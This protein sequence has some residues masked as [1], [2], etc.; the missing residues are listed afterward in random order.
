MIEVRNTFMPL[1]QHLREMSA[2]G[3]L[4]APPPEDDSDWRDI[5]AMIVN[6]VPELLLPLANAVFDTQYSGDEEVLLLPPPDLRQ[7]RD[8][9]LSCSAS[10]AHIGVMEKDGTMSRYHFAAQSGLDSFMATYM[11]AYNVCDTIDHFELDENGITIE[12]T[13]GLVLCLTGCNALPERLSQKIP[14]H[15]KEVYNQIPPVPVIAISAATHDEMLENNL[16]L[17]IPF[18]FLQYKTDLIP[19]SQ[20]R[21]WLDEVLDQY[22]TM[23]GAVMHQ[24]EVGKLTEKQA[25]VLAR[26]ILTGIHRIAGDYPVVR[27]GLTRVIAENLLVQLDADMDPGEF[28][29]GVNEERGN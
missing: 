19:L 4:K 21:E 2:Q 15:P 1:R 28:V 11:L 6:E 10:S 22:R 3:K 26:A 23:C 12:W 18:Y 20:D 24:I 13:H 7:I 17:L 29:F 8:P 5:W 27:D 9:V 25:L 16:Y 14:G